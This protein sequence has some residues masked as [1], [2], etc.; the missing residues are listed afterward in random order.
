MTAT[1]KVKVLDVK[2]S[3]RNE[4][5]RAQRRMIVKLT[6]IFRGIFGHRSAQNKC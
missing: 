2:Q 5:M 1:L 6:L 3:I 4:K